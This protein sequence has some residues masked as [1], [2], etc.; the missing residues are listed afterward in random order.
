MADSQ[1][2]FKNST[3]GRIPLNKIRENAEALR[4][5]VDKEDVKYAQLV[6]SI[7]KHGVMNPISVREIKDPATG[8]ILYGLVDGLHRFTASMDAGL[9]D[10]PAQIGS[11][12]E[13][14]L[15]EAQILANVHRIETKPVQYT[16]ALIG[17]L[18]ANPTLTVSELAARLSHSEQWLKD[19]LGLA[20]LAEPIQKLVD[21]NG[22]TL[23]NAI[24]LSKLPP[25][26]QGDFLQQAISQSPSEFVPMATAVKKEIDTAKRQG[27]EANT[28]Q[29]VPSMRLKRVAEIRDESDLARSMPDTSKVVQ[30]AKANGVKNVEEAIAYALSWVLH[31][32]PVSIAADKAKW[33]N[34]KL[35]QKEAAEKRKAER[36][37][38]KA[39]AASEV[40]AGV[41]G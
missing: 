13:G 19:R 15:L 40:A 17:I 10:I 16:H 27:R 18:S 12:E 24:A 21:E 23:T 35:Q 20:K 14:N 2:N 1:F 32:D 5:E 30:A 9:P 6:D 37:A 31:L 26:K 11:I 4:T 7:R 41:T 3:L 34:N 38:K 25:E 28:A 8:E 39:Q 22:M 36:E 29:F 33:E